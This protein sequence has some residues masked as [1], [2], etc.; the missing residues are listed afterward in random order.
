MNTT[1][2]HFA[3]S[4]SALAIAALLAACG[5]GEASGPPDTQAPTVVITDNVVAAST[6][7]PVTFTFAFNESVGSSFTSDDVVVTGGTKGA[8]AMAAD[9]KSATLVVTPTANAS[10]TLKVDVAAGMFADIAGNK[11]SATYSGS[12]DFS[13]VVKTQMA[14][15]VNFDSATVDYGFVGFGGADAAL[16]ADPTSASNMVGK[17]TRG[18]NSETWA[19]VT[20]SNKAGAGFAP[21][22]PFNANDTR[23]TVRVYSPDAGIPVRL[24]AEDSTNDRITVETEATTTKAGAWETLTFDFKNQA[25]GTAA[26]DVTKTFN[27]VSIFFDFGRAM[28]ASTLKTYYFDDITFLPGAASSGGGAGGTTTLDFSASALKM[29]AF[30]ALGAE[31]ANDPTLASNKVVKLTKV[32]ASETWAGATI[33]P[34]GTGANTVTA[35][36]F[37]TSKVVTLKVYSPAVGEVI[38]LKVETSVDGGINME[39]RA[40]TTKANAWETLTFNYAT[41]SAGTFNAAK[42]YDRVSIFPHFD[43]KVGADSVYYVDDLTYTAVASS[44]SSGGGTGGLVTLTNGVYASN[45]KESPTPWASVE[46][47]TAGR[48]IDDAAGAADWWSGL[49]AGDATPSFYFGYGIKSATKPWGFGAYVKAPGNGT[50]KVAGYTNLRLAVWSND[51]LARTRPT[52]AVI[53]KG[54]AAGG[55]TPEVKGSATVTANGAQTY[56]LPLSAFTLQT[57]CAFANVTAAL[58]AG[59]AEIHIQVLGTNVQYVTSPGDAPGFFAN[60]LNVGPISFN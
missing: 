25:A 36:D 35:F 49:A 22:L 37:A 47:G 42:V 31:I 11:N 13:T 53:L 33:D 1:T 24:K 43:S 6:S 58:A 21:K 60:G 38:M 44:G 12:Q 40:T 50:A 7:G 57:A 59:V 14:L 5:G 39:A 34:L 28:A 41:P 26:L 48:Y 16:A 30:G 19:G 9:G 18:A 15:P 17:V 45:Y 20:I 56:T 27:K 3:L 29:T 23:V 52:Y 4:A 8:F 2:R 51:E 10:G 55:C 54:P 46:G 32:P